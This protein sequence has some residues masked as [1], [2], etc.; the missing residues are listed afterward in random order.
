M[1]RINAT[2]LLLATI[3]VLLALNLATTFRPGTA[4]AG[5]RQ[6]KVMNAP[7]VEDVM[8]AREEG[9]RLLEAF[10]NKQAS[11]GWELDQIAVTGAVVFRK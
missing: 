4:Q 1:R 9:P 11:E 10:L 2:N 7:E 5:G 8:Q 6:Y 3:A